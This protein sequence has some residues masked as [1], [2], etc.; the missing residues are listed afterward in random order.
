MLTINFNFEIPYKYILE[1][2]AAFF[3]IFWLIFMEVPSEN[4]VA[5]T[6]RGIYLSVMVSK[7]TYIFLGKILKVSRKIF[8][9]LQLCSKNQRGTWKTSPSPNSA[10]IPMPTVITCA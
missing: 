1:N 5:M 3:F 4:V 10:N 8:C 9:C 7:S 6:T 2:K